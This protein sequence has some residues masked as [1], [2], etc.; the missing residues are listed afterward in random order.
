MIDYISQLPLQ[1]EQRDMLEKL[2]PVLSAQFNHNQCCL[3]DTRTAILE[4]IRAWS[5]ALGKDP[6][7]TLLWIYGVAGSGKSA[8]S[9]TL[10]EMLA[11]LGALAGSFFCKRDIPDQ[12]D[13]GRVLPS[14]AYTLARVY[15]PYRASVVNAIEAEPDITSNS[16]TYQLKA[17][18]LTPFAELNEQQC[19]PSRPFVVVVDA[20]DECGDD[21]SRTLIAKCLSQIATLAPWLKVLV[22]SRPLP[23]LEQR[24]ASTEQSRIEV[25]NLNAIDVEDDISRY[26][27]SRLE[28][29]IGAGQLGA[30]WLS[31][32]I[33][34]KLVKKAAGLF[35]W[36]STTMK[37][38]QGEYLG[39]AAM[40]AV[41]SEDLEDDDPK[42][43]LD[44][45]YRTV[46]QNTRGGTSGKNL[47]I[48]KTILGTIR[49]TAKNRP[50]TMNGP[51]EFLPRIDGRLELPRE[52]L[53]SIVKELRSV[54]YEDASKGNIIRACH[55]SFL[56]FLDNP[57][58]CAE[59]W[60]HP[61]Q[62][63][64]VMIEK[65]FN[66]MR[67]RLRF[68]ICGL[69]SSCVADADVPE[70]SERIKSDIPENLQYS[71]LY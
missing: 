28:T 16:L 11:Q 66:F 6:A 38:L 23:A 15:E 32:D 57:E 31:D 30:K 58:R 59:F 33:V 70:L 8:I 13:P 14:I 20:L 43:S 29:L 52:V 48:V 56:D 39:D 21:D 37:Y 25:I 64:Q 51:H 10:C 17:L 71:C 42:A 50:L 44:A 9:A 55:P 65:C 2:R 62:L 63:N 1:L 26:T 36:T 47:A 4:R 41:L 34:E 22:T 12:R 69:E 61:E 24:F 45:L 53:E 18:F 7:A 40:E 46:L 3:E 27:R 54:L 67:A 49:I 68:N 35:I 60:V 5:V 19:A